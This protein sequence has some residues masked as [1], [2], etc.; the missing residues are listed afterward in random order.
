[1]VYTD[2]EGRFDSKRMLISSTIVGLTSFVEGTRLMKYFEHYT[3]GL[4]E[5][6]PESHIMTEEEIIEFGER[7]DPQPFHTDRVAAEK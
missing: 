7:W 4:E 2:P 6:L 3:G 5:T 1:L